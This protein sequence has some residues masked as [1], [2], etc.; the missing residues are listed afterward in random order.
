MRK[1][2]LY[3]LATIL[4]YTLPNISRDVVAKENL[5]E[6]SFVTS[7]SIGDYIQ[8]GKYNDAAILWRYVADD[9][10]GKLMV[11]DKILCY[12]PFA[13]F[14]D[15]ILW[16]DSFPRK[17]LN[18]TVSEGEVIWG[19]FDS[20]LWMKDNIDPNEKGFLHESNFTQ[21]EQSVLKPIVQWTMVPYVQLNLATNGNCQVYNAV[22]EY[23]P[24]GPYN[25]GYRRFYE[26]SDFP[27]VYSGASRESEDR[28]FLLDEMQI[29]QIW[30]NFG[31]VR[32]LPTEESNRPENYLNSDYDGYFL[33]TPLCLE[34]YGNFYSAISFITSEGGYNSQDWFSP[35]G[36][37]PAFYLEEDNALIISGSGTA[38]D[39]YVVTGREISV[40]VDGTE[41]TFDQSP[42]VRGGVVYAPLRAIA[43]QLGAAVSWDEAAQ[44]VTV[45][46]DGRTIDL[47]VDM[48]EMY[49]DGVMHW[50]PAPVILKGDRTLVPLQVLT[51]GFGLPAEWDST[52]QTITI[53]TTG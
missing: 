38:E 53:T 20:H 19:N 27:T 15:S 32:A 17:W 5:S 48:Q 50:L 49:V 31:D 25:G 44:K 41:V 34:S 39:P 28:M 26:I 22:K 7:Y 9:V 40:S 43:E 24:G 6:S 33:R 29:Y 21:K 10:N 51:G 8:F 11:S 23:S 47:T 35:S 30:R 14:G 1:I 52:A 45:Q 4:I 42:I 36:I 46:M 16:E 3:L 18:S 37:R 13:Q 2:I 12:K